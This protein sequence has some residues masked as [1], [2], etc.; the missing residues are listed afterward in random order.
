MSM[1]PVRNIARAKSPF[2]MNVEGIA[3]FLEGTAGEV[4]T[5]VYIL[6]N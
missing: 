1:R 6:P 2:A 3:F 4:L 5:E